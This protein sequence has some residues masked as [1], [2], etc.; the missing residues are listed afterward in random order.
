MEIEH[1]L[2]LLVIGY[3]IYTFDIKKKN[4]PV[5]VIL[6]LIGIGLSFLPYFEKVSITEDVIYSIFLPALLFI[7]AY[8]F[9]AKALIQHREIIGFLSTIGLIL[10]VILLGFAIYYIGLY[11][12]G[13]SFI[14]ALL[15]ASILTPTDPVS[16]VSVLKT[17]SDNPDISNIVDGE[18]M[19]NDG[20]SIVLFT[21]ILSMYINNT[22]FILDDFIKS[23]FVV[24]F[25]GIF[26]GLIIGWL[27]SKAVHLF[28]EQKYQ[29]M[30]SIVIAYGGF[31]IAEQLNFSGVLATVTSGILLSW[32][33]DHT[34]KANHYL[35][36]LNGFWG[37][38]EPTLLSL[39][40][41]LIGIEATKYL[42][43]EYWLYSLIIFFVSILIRFFIVA[44]SLKLFSNFEHISLGQSV[45]ISWAGIKG[46]MSVF[47][48]L[49]L[50]LQ[51][52]LNASPIVSI[53]FSVVI[54]SLIFQSL[55]LY[56]L[57]KWLSQD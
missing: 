35:E 41:L 9:S 17:S 42:V 52:N 51:T 3:L 38:I 23:F 11:F 37:V 29:V 14:S 18:S 50:A 48:L 22:S 30:L 54:L 12:I 27:F 4:F 34:N 26:I 40:F 56:P 33:F 24:S 43:H 13:F 44:G 5:P 46:T 36:K 57:S 53:G 10:T 28:N 20:T 45:I 39:L 1:F 8:Q 21:I 47:L 19:I 7:S 32:E 6:L 25:G 2:I 49:T 55:G 16:V 31:H 15:L